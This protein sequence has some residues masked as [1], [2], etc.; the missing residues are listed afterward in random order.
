M[1]LNYYKKE[2]SEKQWKALIDEAINL[3]CSVRYSIYGNIAEIDSTELED[4][5]VAGNN[6]I[7][8]ARLE[9]AQHIHSM[10]LLAADL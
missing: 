4:R 3:G 7:G 10:L 2:Y 8:L 6:A 1:T 9:W 5:L